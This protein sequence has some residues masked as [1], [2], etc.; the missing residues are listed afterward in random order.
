MVS[1]SIDCRYF[2]YIHQYNRLK[3]LR[4]VSIGRFLLVHRPKL[5][6][7]AKLTNARARCII[8]PALL[9]ER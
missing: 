6:S 9:D 1:A 7:H 4:T 2:Y 5:S 3:L 8:S